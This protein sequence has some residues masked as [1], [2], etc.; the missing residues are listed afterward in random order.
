MVLKLKKKYPNTIKIKIFEK[1]PIAVIIEQK[2]KFYLSDK[3]D[4]IE[5]KSLS[6]YQDLPYVFGNKDNFKI[7]YSN[8]KKID[9]PLNIIKKYTFYETNRWDLETKNNKIIK[10]PSENYIKSL[11]NYLNLK[12]KNDFEKYKLFDYRIRNQL[13]LN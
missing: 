8:L 7:F 5:F 3:I 11:E 10:L 4:L 12:S 9:F 13:I 6:N 2:K 1:T